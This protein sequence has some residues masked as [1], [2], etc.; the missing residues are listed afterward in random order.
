MNIKIIGITIVV[1]IA[2]LTGLFFTGNLPGLGI[3]DNG[4]TTKPYDRSGIFGNRYSELIGPN[5]RKG[6]ICSYIAAQNSEEIVAHGSL[7]IDTWSLA[8][9]DKYEYRV[10]L[11]KDSSSK[12]E[13]VSAPGTATSPFISNA[14]PGEIGVGTIAIGGT[15][16]CKDYS[17]SII[18]SSYSNGAVKVELLAHIKDNIIDPYDWWVVSSDE[19]YLYSGWGG[20][21]LPKDT[22]GTY[23][24]TFEIG[25][26]VKINVQ[27]SYGAYIGENTWR[28]T[29]QTPM[30]NGG[31]VYKTQDYGNNV[32]TYFEFDVTQDMFILGGDNDWT[33]QIYNTLV[34]KGTLH[35]D[36]I[37]FRAKAPS[38]VTFSSLNSQY[39]TGTAIT[40]TLSAVVNPTTQL[41]ISKFKVAIIYG[42]YDVLLPSDPL[43]QQWILPWS[44]VVAS[45]NSA[46]VTFTPKSQ[47]YV[48]IHAKAYDTDGRASLHTKTMTTWAYSTAPANEDQIDDQTGTHD[49][50]GGHTNDW[51][52]WDPGQQ[53]PTNWLGLIIKIIIVIAIFIGCIIAGV[54]LPIPIYGKAA[55]II[56]GI[57]VAI[58]YYMYAPL[59]L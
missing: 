30:S 53:D 20:L 57:I 25:E 9:A 39:Q 58:L 13:L 24:S 16:Q 1:V 37:D 52:P 10:Y 33:L 7:S 41:S 59:L 12:Y 34:P 14:N 38:D 49:Y 40:C 8:M 51:F 45:G 42:T 54:F 19:A 43:S 17:F 23:K 31:T 6:F 28:V 26:H 44:D 15:I 3:L 48:T 29:L 18:G 4:T 11:K 55:V 47:S 50:G 46:T 36:T 35:I 27:T 22:N 56:I 2:M 21:Y 32:N 5:G